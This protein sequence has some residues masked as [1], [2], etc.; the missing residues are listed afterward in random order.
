MSTS[1]ET[2]PLPV[3]A[4]SCT[5]D[6]AHVERTAVLELRA[7][8]QR[9]RLGPVSALAVDRTLHAE[10]TGDRPAAVLDARIVRTWT[11]RGPLPADD[12]SALR[13]R[14]TE[15]EE[16]HTDLEQRRDRLRTRLDVLGR[17]ATDLLREIGEGAGFGEAER[18]R[19][20]R[21][22]DRVDGERDAHGERLRAV[23][24]QAAAVA[25]EL[26]EVRQVMDLTETEPAELV[27]HIELTVDASAAGPAGLRLSHLTPR[28]V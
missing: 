21:E 4:V 26:A 23:E 8:T 22:L 15:L 11:P 14:T 1:T 5:E 17:L 28:T 6:R 27:A 13:R 25:A 7:G 16:E 12:D 19:W 9:L 3:T 10:L 18:E 2:V 24:A 20:A